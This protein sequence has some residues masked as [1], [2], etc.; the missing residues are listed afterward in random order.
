MRTS[1]DNLM[2]GINSLLPRSVHSSINCLRFSRVLSYLNVHKI[3]N[4]FAPEPPV[5]ARVACE[6]ALLFGR[7]KRASPLARAFSRG[8]LRLPK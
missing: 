7:V 8:S 5:T 4:P 6:Q 1:R 2:N 3:L